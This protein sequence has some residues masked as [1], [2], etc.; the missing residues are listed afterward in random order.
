MPRCTIIKNGRIVDPK[1]N[2][3]E[4]ADLYIL[5][6]KIASKPSN[7]I[8]DTA[9]I[10][11]AQG[12]VVSP[13][14]VDLHVHFR[15]PGQK[16]KETIRTGTSA[17][18][19]GG[20]TS[21]V[22]MPNTSPAVDNAGTVQL[23]K[24]IVDKE[25]VVNV[26][27]TGTI[28]VG[29][30]GEAL[31]PTGSLSRM[32]IVAIS[33]GGKCVQNAGL[34]RRALQYAHMFNVPV[35]DHCQDY[36]L[37]ADGVM[38][39]GF[40]STKLGLR[41]IHKAAEDIIVARDITL[42]THTGAHIHLQHISSKSAVDIIRRAKARGINVTAEVTPHHLALTDSEVESFNTNFKM[43]PPLREEED[44]I[45]LLEAL[46]DGT[47]DCIATGH[48]PHT[49]YEKDVEFDYAPFGV[50]GLETALSISLAQLY[51]S[52]RLSLLGTLSL[53]TSR[54][55]EILKLNKGTL[56]EGADADVTL[57][58]P[59]ETWTPQFKKFFSKS[60]NSPWIGREL[61]GKVKK[62]LVAGKLVF[63]GQKI[64]AD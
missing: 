24:D 41:G 64:L 33:D 49:D 45:A 35:I 27:P 7:E 10:I 11:D 50:I 31:A 28:T 13:G 52:K 16:H 54:P 62:T 51:H 53:L 58:D 3:D 59:E 1:N 55:A 25:G 63:D 23:I 40:V 2:R 9:E 20:F 30:Q 29:R 17:A 22:C 6:G 5:D 43:N 44:R 48:A 42:S 34:M 47:I 18:A 4:A 12:L 60:S 8:L 46:E 19:A 32:G 57:F 26:F 14:L 21:V 61:K 56:S 36:S 37:S 38:N 39:E 15:V